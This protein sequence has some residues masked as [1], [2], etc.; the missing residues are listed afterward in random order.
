MIIV[1][2]QGC[3]DGYLL[4]LQVIGK[5]VASPRKPKEGENQCGL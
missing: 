1:L 2:A 5:K 4:K 3:D